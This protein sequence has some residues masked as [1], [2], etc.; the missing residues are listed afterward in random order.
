MKQNYHHIEHDVFSLVENHVH[1]QTWFFAEAYVSILWTGPCQKLWG[2]MLLKSFQ[3]DLL[4]PA[5]R[6]SPQP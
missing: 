2:S 3:L 6:L 5:R 1:R 4:L